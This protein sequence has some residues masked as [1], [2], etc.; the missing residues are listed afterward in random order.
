MSGPPVLT[1]QEEYL[2]LVRRRM[3]RNPIDQRN[4]P[5]LGPIVATSYRLP[6]GRTLKPAEPFTGPNFIGHRFTAPG[7]LVVLATVDDT[8]YWGKLRHVSISYKSRHPTWEE[9]KAVRA[10]FFH[11]EVDVMMM[12]PRSADY[13]AGIPG[14]PDTHVF[15]LWQC[16]ERW[17][18]R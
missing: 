10:I 16:P 13:I 18:M 17:G 7:G 3:E 2:E 15:H 1:P 12:L 11:S 5:R 4:L 14:V 8:Y 9:I 6:D